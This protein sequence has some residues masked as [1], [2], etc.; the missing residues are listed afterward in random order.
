MPKMI[1]EMAANPDLGLLDA[2]SHFGLRNHMVLQYWR[3]AGQLKAYAQASD[4]RHIPAWQAFNRAIGTSGD[5]GI[6][7]ETYVVPPGHAESIYVNMPRYGL[8][9]AGA[10]H[11]AKGDRATAEKRLARGRLP[12]VY[13]ASGRARP[14][15]MSAR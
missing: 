9:L 13:S 6:W 3:S 1:K 11:P 5:V 2:R 14:F 12:D 15:L 10:L 4:K 8:G 7:H